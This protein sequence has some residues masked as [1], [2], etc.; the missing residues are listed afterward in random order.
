MTATPI[1]TDDELYALAQMHLPLD[2]Y[3]RLKKQSFREAD[4]RHTSHRVI[5]PALLLAALG[6]L[7]ILPAPSNAAV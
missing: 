1:P 3:E 5:L 7:G 2:L 4:S 6:Q